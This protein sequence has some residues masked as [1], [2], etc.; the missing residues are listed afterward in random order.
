MKASKHSKHECLVLLPIPFT[1]NLSN[2]W[3]SQSKVLDEEAEPGERVK[4]NS[5]PRVHYNPV[6]KWTN[7]FTRLQIIH[8]EPK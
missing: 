2:T 6:G 4:H 8:D 5:G 1:P 7:V 3:E